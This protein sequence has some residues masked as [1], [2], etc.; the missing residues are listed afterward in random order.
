ELRDQA[1]RA[2]KSCFLNIAEGLPSFQA[3]MRRKFF[4]AARGSLGEVAAAVDLATAIGAV[5]ANPELD[6]AMARLAPIVC[7]LLRRG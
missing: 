4:A 5:D 6:A 3:G 2:A 7:G 1:T